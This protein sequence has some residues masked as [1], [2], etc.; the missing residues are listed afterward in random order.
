MLE[1]TDRAVQFAWLSTTQRDGFQ[2]YRVV[3]VADGQALRQAAVEDGIDPDADRLVVPPKQLLKFK[4]LF[5]NNFPVAAK[6][7]G[8]LTRQETS[9]SC[10]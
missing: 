6:R 2:A 1:S 8:F 5:E 3:S 4:G 9:T 7:R 10:I